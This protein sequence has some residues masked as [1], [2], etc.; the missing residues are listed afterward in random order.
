[1][2]KIIFEIISIIISTIVTSIVFWLV[3]PEKTIAAKIII[4]ILIVILII[5]YGAIKYIFQLK[6]SLE[7]SNLI[8]LPKLLTIEDHYYIFEKSDIFEPQSYCILYYIDKTKKKIALGIVDTIIDSSGAI[9][10]KLLQEISEETQIQ[11]L[12]SKKKIYLKPTITT[13]YINIDDITQGEE[14]WQ[15]KNK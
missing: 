11:M 7:N 3:S 14:W 12:K 4:P 5:L 8:K 13:D 15:A 6:E 2:N 10:V 9:Q 1:M